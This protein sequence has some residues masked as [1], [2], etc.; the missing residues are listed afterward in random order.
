MIRTTLISH[1]CLLIQTSDLTIMTDPVF[2]DPL[3][4]EV[5]VL[6]PQRSIDFDKFPKVDLLYIS[7]RHQDHFDVRTLAFLKNAS[8]L[9]DDFILVAPNDP[10][11]LEVLKEL[12]YPEPR[13]SEDFE[14]FRVKG[15][16]L[17][18][19]PSLIQANFP[20]HGLLVHDGET[21]IWNEVDTIVSPEIIQYLKQMYPKVDLVHSRFL[22]LLEGNFSF[23]QAVEL[24]FDE[25]SSFIKVVDAI[26]PRFVVPGSAGFKYKEEFAF[27]NQQSF[28]TTQEQFLGDLKTFSPQIE[29]ST[30]F[31]GDVVEVTPEKVEVLPQASD[32]IKTTDNDSVDIEFKPVSKVEPIAFIQNGKSPEEEWQQAED[33]ILN[34]MPGLLEKSEMVEAW[35]SWKI[36]YQL[37]LFGPNESKIWTLD[38]GGEVKFNSG[39]MDKINLYEGIG[40]SEFN[41]FIRGETSWDF[42]GVAAQYRT[43][44]N[45]YRVEQ[46]RFEMFP[47]KNK[48]P[49]PLAQLFP[50]GPEMDRQK[51]MKDVRRWKGWKP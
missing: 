29:S 4:E 28:P 15:A 42:A 1:A 40:L 7:H 5:N 18:P 21:T 11:L 48:F 2:F 8:I 3:W 26:A 39:R 9:K 38:F 47:Q 50:D 20:E 22:P 23:H 13:V 14:S 49:Q 17:T 19:T 31:P 43:F 36:V 10:I 44:H 34:Q 27:L 45:I 30:F 24:P 41:Q 12:E 25:Y 46:G 16:V 33:F 6:C 37:E 51:F 32:F 35:K